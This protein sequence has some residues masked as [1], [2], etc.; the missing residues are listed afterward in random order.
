MSRRARLLS[1][2]SATGARKHS[3][4]EASGQLRLALEAGMRA[5][6]YWRSIRHRGT[7]GLERAPGGGT[8]PPGRG[9]HGV[10]PTIAGA[11]GDTG[12]EACVLRLKIAR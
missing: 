6:P 12:P 8:A 2:V 5:P 10:P 3:A 4:P 11:T 1:Q 7:H 9:P